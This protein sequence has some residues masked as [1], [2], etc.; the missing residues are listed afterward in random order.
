MYTTPQW[1]L[2]LELAFIPDGTHTMHMYLRPTYNICL[3]SYTHACVIPT[4]VHNVFVYF[5]S[6]CA[7]KE[8]KKK[9]YRCVLAQ[10]RHIYIVVLYTYRYILLHIIYIPT[11]TGSFCPLRGTTACVIASLCDDSDDEGLSRKTILI[12]PV[13]PLGKQTIVI[14]VNAPI[15]I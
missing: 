2:R 10:G 15:I 11:G 7:I 3:Y 1:R 14:A 12:S 5:T 9:F 4:C 6:F 8:N 13:D